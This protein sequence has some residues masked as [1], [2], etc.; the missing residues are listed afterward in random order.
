AGGG[1]PE[2]IDEASALPA[3]AELPAGTGAFAGEG[4]DATQTLR[5]ETPRPQRQGR[6]RVRPTP[7]FWI[8]LVTLVLVAGS[9]YWAV[10]AVKD[11]LVV[12]D[13][14]VPNLVGV[15]QTRAQ[16]LLREQGLILE[17]GKQIASERPP[18][19]VLSQE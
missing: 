19:E 1:D 3:L 6:R 15:P 5:R 18:G 7:A 8:T 14:T 10:E 2:E 9:V 13:A 4:G 11:W 12:P 17:V 16:E